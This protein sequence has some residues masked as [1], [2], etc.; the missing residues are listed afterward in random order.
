MR[1]DELIGALVADVPHRRLSQTAAWWLAAGLAVAL[2]ALVFHALVGPRPDIAAAAGTPRFV[3]KFVLTL[4]LAGSAFVF[5]GELSRPG[6]RPLARAWLVAAP[7]LLAI[8]VLVELVVTPADT[9]VTRAVGTNALVCLAFIPVIGLAP[10]AVFVAA[11][12]YGAP[13]RPRLAGAVAGL[14]AGGLA[15]TFYA[16]HCTDDSPL[17]VAI[18]YTLAIA[19]LAGLGALAAGRF[20][21]W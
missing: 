15:A 17:F 18:W 6:A 13:T 11:L 12:R 14:L 21:R 16:A 2:A 9:W 5:A 8:A 1:T 7:A 3:L 20:A 19:G 10:L 4:A